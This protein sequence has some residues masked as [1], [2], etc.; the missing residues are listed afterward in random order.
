MRRVPTRETGATEKPAIALMSISPH[1][2]KPLKI[3]MASSEAVPFAKTGGLAD[4]AGALP[5]EL[6]RQGHDVRLVI[7]RYST[8]DRSGYRFTEHAR[9]VVPSSSGPVETVVERTTLH[10]SNSNSRGSVSVFAV[11]HDPF[12]LRPGLYQER[13]VDYPDNLERFCFF[14]RAVLEL[15]IAFQHADGWK[16]DVLHLHDWQT[17]L[18]AVYMRTLYAGR[19]EVAGVRSILTLHN[20]A[21]QGLFPGERFAETGLPAA[22]FTP[23]GLEFYGSLNLLKGGILFADFLTTVSPT[24]SLE[25]QTPEFGFGLEGVL[26]ERKDRLVGLVNGVDVEAWNPAADP[27]IPARYSSADLSGKSMCKQALQREL[28]LPVSDVPLLGIVS[29]LTVQKGLDLLL[30]IVPDLMELDLQLAVLGTGDPAYETELR[31]LHAKFPRK[32][33]VRI[34]FDEGL[35]HRIE[36]GADMFVMPSRYEPCGL[37]Q[38]YSM[39]YG[40]VPIVRRTG[41]LADTVVPYSPLAVR[42]RRA[43]GFMFVETTPH[44]LLTVICLA[45]CVYQDRGAWRSLI[46]GGMGTDVSWTGSAQAYIELYR[47]VVRAASPIEGAA[48]Q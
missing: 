3:L 31:A 9:I 1:E 41:G 17:A 32:I 36:A 8:L 39:R 34:G 45:L 47:R 7:P 16:P 2:S 35:A 14:S 30:S 22:L 44:A 4:V 46:Q 12:F 33:G 18:C 48:E 5:L 38:L 27:L 26:A 40:T 15:L 21:Y 24:Y 20:L 6:A 11:R 43:T 29:R 10:P 37:S 13:G 23:A 19:P 28:A 42:E 25:I